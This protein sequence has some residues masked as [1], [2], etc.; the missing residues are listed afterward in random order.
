MKAPVRVAVTGA[1]GQISYSLLFRIASGEMPGKDQPVILQ[2]LEIEPAMNAL[3]GVIM[4]LE[5]CAFPLVQ[6]IIASHDPMIAFKDIDIALLVGARPRSKGMERK[7]LLEA[8]GAIF[9]VQGKALAAVAKKDVKVLVVGNPA[10]TNALIA[11]KSAAGLNPRNFTAMLRLD[12][13]RAYS[14]LA[15]KTASHTTEINKI[16][17]WGNHSATQYP[18]ISAATVKGTAASDLVDQNWLV[19]DFIPTVQKRGAAIIDARGL[20]SAASAANA[21][22]EHIRDWVLGTKEGEFVSMG[23]PSDGSYGI[24]EGVIYG[25]PCSCKNGEYTIVQGLAVSEFSRERMNATLQELTEE[26]DAVKHLL[27]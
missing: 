3:K 22:I 5:D 25:F 10:N 24:P 19:T 6:G 27:A 1:A 8:N 11:L 13:N 9:T 4:E 16:V 26:R 21:A 7:D 2:L 20:S 15:A 23:V 18:D 17:V 14:Q 12:H